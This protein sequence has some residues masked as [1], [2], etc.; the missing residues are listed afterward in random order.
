MRK[1]EAEDFR[2]ISLSVQKI[3]HTVTE[4][5]KVSDKIELFNLS[6]ALKAFESRSLEVRLKGLGSIKNIIKR[7]NPSK[8]DKKSNIGVPLLSRFQ[9]PAAPKDEEEKKKERPIDPVFVLNWLREVNFVEK[10]FTLNA[11]PEEIRQGMVIP[12]FLAQH[13]SLNSEH[14][15]TLW[16][17]A[18]VSFFLS[19][20]SSCLQS[21][22]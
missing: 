1:D 8:D 22:N 5:E 3:M 4:F 11:H 14:I 16:Q 18:Q 15:G 2:F 20:F 13:K 17:I 10:L 21:E 9:Q 19:S 12:K 6:V 7:A